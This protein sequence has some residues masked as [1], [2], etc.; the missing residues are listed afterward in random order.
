MKTKDTFTVADAAFLIVEKGLSTKE[1][2]EQTIRRWIRLYKKEWNKNMNDVKHADK[3]QEEKE[4]LAHVEAEKKGLRA[5]MVSKKQGYIIDSMDF[6]KFVEMKLKKKVG[7]V[8]KEGDFTQHKHSSDMHSITNTWVQERLDSGHINET[9]DSYY[10]MGFEDGFKAAMD[11]LEKKNKEKYKL[12]NTEKKQLISL[13]NKYRWYQDVHQIN[14]KDIK[15]E[16]KD[17]IK[18]RDDDKSLE[19]KFSHESIPD[20]TFILH[21]SLYNNFFYSFIDFRFKSKYMMSSHTK[22]YMHKLFT[23]NWHKN[24]AE[25]TNIKAVKNVLLLIKRSQLE[26]KHMVDNEDKFKILDSS[27]AFIDRLEQI[28]EQANATEV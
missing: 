6:V 3:T 5:E 28:L 26:L 13:P 10:Q 22:L 19:I 27:Y 2:S 8:Y 24:N 7:K 18:V 14:I 21:I 9:V 16:D 1:S 11:F 25:K 15:T 12:L 23:F 20:L 17:I 4:E